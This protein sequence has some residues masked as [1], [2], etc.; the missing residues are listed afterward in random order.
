M[1]FDVARYYTFNVVGSMLPF[2][3]RVVFTDAVVDTSLDVCM[4]TLP[5]GNCYPGFLQ[6][7]RPVTFK[8]QRQV[9]LTGAVSYTH[10]RA[11]ETG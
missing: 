6:A 4:R 7:G 9:S 1:D 11:H 8:V 5:N 3:Y 10:L 2:D